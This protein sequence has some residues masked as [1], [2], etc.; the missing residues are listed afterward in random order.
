MSATK[1]PVDWKKMRDLVLQRINA[2]WA[3]L[4]RDEWQKPMWH[5]Q[6]PETMESITLSPNE[7]ITEVT[8]LSNIGKKYI[9]GAI[10]LLNKLQP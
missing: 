8:A 2:K 1:E 7:I 3:G 6:D 10:M 9:T 4:S 5:T